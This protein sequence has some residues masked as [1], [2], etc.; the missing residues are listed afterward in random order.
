[1][2]KWGAIL[3][4][5]GFLGGFVG[6]VIFTPEAN[7]GPLLGIFVT[8]PLGFVLGLIVGFVLSLRAG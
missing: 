3:G 2:L 5:I 7:Q 1:M 4:V 8:G 6:P